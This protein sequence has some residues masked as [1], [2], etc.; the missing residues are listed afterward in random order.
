MSLV[1]N[2]KMALDFANKLGLTEDAAK[3][4]LEKGKAM[5]QD[6]KADRGAFEENIDGLSDEELRMTFVPNVYQKDIYKI[7]Y[8]RLKA[9]GIKLISFDI[10]DTIDD[11]VVNKLQAKVPGLKVTMPNDAKK[12][13]QELKSMGFIVTLLT[14]AGAKLAEDACAAL[15]A[16]GYIARAHKPETRSF[17]EMLDNYKLEKSQMAH[18]GNSMRAD[19]AGGN[20]FGITTCLVRRAG[21]SMKLVKFAAK[22]MGLP[23]KGHLVRKK[24]LERGLWRKHHKHH[25]DDQYY[26]LGETQQSSPNFNLLECPK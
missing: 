5:L 16:D 12:L 4:L 14:N 9:N 7:D 13:F 22:R 21:Y 23:T 3:Y 1:D 15:K 10:D 17:E 20:K 18:V 8:A 24:L 11:S 6:E 2:G 26:Q 19:V 25:H